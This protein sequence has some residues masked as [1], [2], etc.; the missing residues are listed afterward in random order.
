MKYLEKATALE[1]KHTNHWLN[2]GVAY[3]KLKNNQAAIATYEKALKV[4]PNDP[5]LLNNLGVALRKARRY[6]EAIK[7]HEQAMAADPYDPDVSRNLAIAYRGAKRY[8]EAIPIYIKSI[9]LGDGGPPDLLFDLAS[10]YEKVGNTQMAI[11]TFER[12]IAAT[13]KSDPE[14]AQR[15]QRAVENLKKR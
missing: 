10:C 3:R 13:K 8:K 5:Q 14:A 12:Y 7:A 15:A 1:P 6:D 11:A 2:L 4:I 9:E